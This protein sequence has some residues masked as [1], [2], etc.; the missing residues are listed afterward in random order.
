VHK[1]Y[2]YVL[3][4]PSMP[5][6]VKIGRSIHGGRQRAKEIY[7]TGV[8]TPFV[9]EFE[10]LTEDPKD[11]E[12]NIH[13]ALSRYRE[14]NNREFF[15]LSVDEAIAGIITE[16]SENY[17]MSKAELIVD[18]VDVAEMEF[19]LSQQGVNIDREIIASSFYYIDPEAVLQ[20][21]S[22]LKKIRSKRDRHLKLVTDNIKNG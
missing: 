2:I 20:A 12:L 6:L 21:I 5:N 7:Q 3:S 15:R 16:I 1:G 4:N 17:I 10:M 9:L 8:P 11:M 13:E 22:K 18:E 14:N 19:K